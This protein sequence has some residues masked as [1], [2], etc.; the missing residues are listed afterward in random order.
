MKSEKLEQYKGTNYKKE[1]QHTICPICGRP[2]KIITGNRYGIHV[3]AT[4]DF[5]C[6][7]GGRPV[8]IPTRKEEPK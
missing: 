8:G 3:D 7:N 6:E 2:V 1:G 5:F 4:G